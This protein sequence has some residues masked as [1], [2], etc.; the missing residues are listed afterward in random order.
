MI[1][2]TV[3]SAAVSVWSPP[4]IAHAAIPFGSGTLQPNRD[5]R[6]AS[7][8]P[9]P[10]TPS[11]PQAS[12]ANCIPKLCDQDRP[13]TLH[14]NACRHAHVLSNWETPPRIMI[15]ANP[16]PTL[17]TWLQMT[18]GPARKT[19][20]PSRPSPST[21]AEVRRQTRVKDCNMRAEVLSPLIGPRTHE[22]QCNELAKLRN[23]AAVARLL[24]CNGNDD[25][26]IGC[27]LDWRSATTRIRSLLRY[28]LLRSL[29]F[30][31]PNN[32]HRCHMTVNAAHSNQGYR[33][34]ASD[35][36]VEK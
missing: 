20:Y 31:L 21:A 22:A 24:V 32:G 15:R 6:I 27:W 3:T 11:C 17:C 35:Y 16:Q 13:G 30:L 7:P 9:F 4:S 19:K 12:E 36:P 34:L 26:G 14:T 5:T 23:E 8:S 10:A 1:P 29:R 33:S 2:N 28:Q 25:N 18:P